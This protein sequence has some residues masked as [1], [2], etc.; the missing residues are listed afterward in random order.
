MHDIDRLYPHVRRRNYTHRAR[1]RI[2]FQ[3]LGVVDHL[4][5]NDFFI[6]HWR[7]QQ[8]YIEQVLHLDFCTRCKIPVPSLEGAICSKCAHSNE[9]AW[10]VTREQ[11]EEAVMRSLTDKPIIPEDMLEIFR[12]KQ[13]GVPTRPMIQ[14]HPQ[15]SVMDILAKA[16]KQS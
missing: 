16:R 2:A 15:V 1:L 11:R 3:E 6:R 13:S 5:P 7:D 4:F 12:T 10:R 8:A 9:H 14:E